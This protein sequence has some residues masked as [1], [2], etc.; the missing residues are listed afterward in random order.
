MSRSLSINLY[1]YFFFSTFLVL[2]LVL[3]VMESSIHFVCTY[4][5]FS[6]VCKFYKPDLQIIPL[7]SDQLRFMDSVDIGGF[8]LWY[9]RMVQFQFLVTFLAVFFLVCNLY[10]S[11]LYLT[12]YF[13]HRKCFIWGFLEFRSSVFSGYKHLNSNHYLLLLAVLPELEMMQFRSGNYLYQVCK[14]YFSF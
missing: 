13:G 3:P 8:W 9:I 12:T 10:K 5:D 2:F 1:L 7:V 14:S 11:G 6:L 4:S